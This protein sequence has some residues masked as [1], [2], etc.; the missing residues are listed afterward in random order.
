DDDRAAAETAR[1][2]LDSAKP[3]V[4]PPKAAIE[5]A[6]TIIIQAKTG[7][8]AAQA[9]ERRIAADFGEGERKAPR[10]GRVQNMVAGPAECG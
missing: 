3:Q 8:E 10:D 7:V 6:R 2:A 5:A 4:S 1:V 9:H